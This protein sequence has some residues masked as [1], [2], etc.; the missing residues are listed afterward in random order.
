[1]IHQ[2]FIVHPLQPIQRRDALQGKPATCFE[3]TLSILEPEI[4]DQRD[5]AL[6]VA[7][8]RGSQAAIVRLRVA[9]PLSPMLMITSAF[10]T[11]CGLFLCSLLVMFVFKRRQAS[12]VETLTGGSTSGGS[13][14]GASSPNVATPN[15]SPS[16]RNSAHNNSSKR[17]KHAN[18][19]TV[20]KKTHLNG[21]AQSANGVSHEHQHQTRGVVNGLGNGLANGSMNPSAVA[22]LN[23]TDGAMEPATGA[24]GGANKAAQMISMASSDTSCD[25]KQLLTS[26]SSSSDRNSSSASSSNQ[27]IDPFLNLHSAGHSTANSSP[28]PMNHISVDEELQTPTHNMYH[29]GEPSGELSSTQQIHQNNSAALIYANIDYSNPSHLHRANAAALGE[30]P[31]IGGN[32]NNHINNSVSP[33]TSTAASLVYAPSSS[34]ASRRQQPMLADMD[35]HT[36]GSK[37][38]QVHSPSDGLSLIS[39]TTAIQN[40]NT[41]SV[42]NNGGERLSRSP[43]IASQQHQRSSP[44]ETIRANVGA[45]IAMM[46]SLAAAAATNTGPSISMQSASQSGVLNGAINQQLA[47]SRQLRKPGPPKPPKPSIQQRSRFYQQQQQQQNGA[48]LVMMA[49]Q[50]NTIHQSDNMTTTNPASNNDLA[51]EYSRIAF[52]A[53]AEL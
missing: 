17:K 39:A 33:V 52:P 31:S 11:I 32:G 13:S 9:S 36:N 28:T 8:E 14:T 6:I 30:H 20:D 27:C 44:Q 4:T 49:Q 41:T 12:G 43:S 25:Q 37:Q 5:Y 15:C 1:M 22:D 10:V 16:Q 23:G 18:G 35:H 26:S 2:R 48:G 53:R 3:A 50:G 21:N 34:N 7:N 46:N 45:T 29:T 40:S 38:Q 42:N 24:I 47:N 51:V 19:S